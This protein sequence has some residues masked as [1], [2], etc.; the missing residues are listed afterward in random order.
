[1]LKTHTRTYIGSDNGDSERT[2]DACPSRRLRPWPRPCPDGWIMS[3]GSGRAVHKREFVPLPERVDGPL[4]GFPVR[5]RLN[6]PH[7]RLPRCD[8]VVTAGTACLQKGIISGVSVNIMT[9]ETKFTP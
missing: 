4:P 6:L 8:R 7:G 2:G 9:L 5:S 1:M 3:P